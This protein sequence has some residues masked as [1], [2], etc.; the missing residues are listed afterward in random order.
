MSLLHI[1]IESKNRQ[2]ELDSI[3]GLAALLITFFHFPKWNPVLDTGLINNG[4]LAMDL[5]FVLSGY[6]I[7]DNY[8]RRVSNLE[9]FAKF[10]FKR[11]GRIYLVHV[12]FLLLF[13][14]I[15]FAKSYLQE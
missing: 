11:I 9:D 3:R 2:F 12:L 5:F 8:F 6:V 14:I 1:D 13:L 15:E 4:Y 7:F 10:L